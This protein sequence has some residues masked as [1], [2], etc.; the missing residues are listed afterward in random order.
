MPCHETR[1]TRHLM[2]MSSS[3]PVPNLLSV[4]VYLHEHEHEHEQKT[5]E[6]ATLVRSHPHFRGSS[7]KF[8]FHIF[9]ILAAFISDSACWPSFLPPGPV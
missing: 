1:N 4:K 6:R 3:M 5:K 7:R 9:F 8:A 2:K